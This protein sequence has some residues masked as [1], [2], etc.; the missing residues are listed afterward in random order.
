MRKILLISSCLLCFQPQLAY[1]QSLDLLSFAIGYYDVFGHE[2]EAELR[3]EYRPD[4]RIF[5]ENLKPWVG[6]ELTSEKSLWAGGGLLFD[7]NISN[8]WYLTPSFGA[9]LYSKGD[10]DKDLD[11]PIQF[12]SQLEISYEFQDLSRAGIS[13][14][15]SSNAGLGDHNPGTEAIGFYWHIPLSNI[16]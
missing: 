5:M 9:G 10:S 11:H 15:H 8:S 13:L 14:S 3:A 1:A 7:Y 2:S 12:R 16:F 6:I 4:S